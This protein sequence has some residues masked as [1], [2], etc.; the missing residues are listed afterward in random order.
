MSF[1]LIDNHLSP[2]EGEIVVRTY[3]CTNLSP[4]FALIGLKTDG[5]LTVTNKRVVYFAEG[6][7][8]YGAAG[9]SKLYN[10]VPIADVANLSLS[11]GTRFSFLRL[12]CGLLFGQIPAAIV[13][14]ILSG[15]MS[16]LEGAGGGTNP[17]LLRFGVFLQ[18]SVAILLVFRSLLIPRESIVRLML[19]A[20]SLSLVLSVPA[21]VLV[22]GRGLQLLPSIYQSGLTILSIPLA[23]YWLWCL[24][25]FIRREYLTM[26]I[27]SKTNWPPSIQIAGVSWWGRI[28]VAADLAYGMAP[29]IDADAMF[30]ELGAMIT[31]IQTLGDHGIQKWLRIERDSI[32]KNANENQEVAVTYR[33][34]STRYTLATIVLIGLL[35]GTESAWYASGAKQRL[36]SQMRNELASARNT[37]EQDTS[38]KE[39]VPKS[40]AS[41]EQETV[42]GETAFAGNKFTDAMAHWTVAINT[43]SNIPNVAAAMKKASALQSQYKTELGTVYLQETASERLKSAYLMKAFT[44]LIDQH[45]SPNE[46]WKTVKQGAAEARVLDEQTNWAQMGMAWENAGSSL[47]QATRLMHADIWVKHAEG[48]IKKG[49]ASGAI[50]YADNALRAL[51]GYSYAIQR[52]ELAGNMNKYD[53]WLRQEIEE[54]AVSAESMDELTKQLDLSGGEDWKTIKTSV[55]NARV[56]ANKNEWDKSNDEWKNALSKMPNVILAMR[57]EK[58][59][60]DARRGNWAT[61]SRLASRVLQD[62]PDHL[63]AN[64]LKKKADGIESARAAALAYQRAMSEVLNHEVASDYIKTGDM[65][66]FVAHMD[67][68]GQE[69]WAQVKDAISKA[70][71]FSANEQG[72]ES[73]NEWSKAYTLFPSAV[74][75]MRAEIWMEQADLEVKNNNWTK[76]LI[77][78]ENAL[79]EKPDHV[80]AK[81]LRDQADP[82]EKKRLMQTP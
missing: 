55:E 71:A 80:R 61:V 24:Y 52:K 48:E 14:V 5:Y 72:V 46:P 68:Y 8:V 44:D 25:W 38:I 49:N 16:V 3:H 74:H 30:K 19:A 22:H 45:P 6:S 70:E 62:N 78:V 75:R 34:T 82:I 54:G 42:A 64:E 13:T 47:P 65:T 69:E 1:K 60:T 43:Y 4:V 36:A 33:K 59:E 9:N 2:A 63:R 10:E 58:L 57:L 81:Q 66:D 76:V 32:A 51:P 31:D 17:Y 37:V 40:L 11:K 26:A 23:C 27:R 53:Q 18:L 39:L 20:S 50:E 41:A 7:S 21:L 77:Y 35:V 29:A 28:N 15:V 67:K 56:L 12:L 73:A 79:R